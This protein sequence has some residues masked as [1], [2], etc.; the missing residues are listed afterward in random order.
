MEPL[1][2]LP[3]VLSFTLMND[4]RI[5]PKRV[6][7]K[8]IKKDIPEEV[9][10]RAQKGGTKVHDALRKRMKLREPLPTEFANHEGVCTTLEQHESVKHLELKLGVRRDGTA[11][12]FFARDVAL[13][14][15]LDLTCSNSPCALLVD[16]KSGKPWEDPFE[17]KVQS[18]LLAARYP[19]L[20]QFT[21]FYYWLRTGA[22]GTLH[23]LDPTRTWLE[24]CG[25]AKAIAG[26]V[27]RLDF[28]PDEG[29]L[30]PWCPVPKGTGA[31]LD[32]VCEFR[33][34]PP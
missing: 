18:L 17:L 21:G 6:W 11:C 8:S 20:K 26:R 4:Y 31:L 25:L 9:K 14:G 29:P 13:R 1:P 10:T 3:V 28:P 23:S 24:V 2:E 16:W 32:P 7:H 22:V 5:C 34:D 33:K 27:A 15:A 30:C 19:D 12:D